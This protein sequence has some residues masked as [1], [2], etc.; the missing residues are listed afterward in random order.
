MRIDRRYLTE[1]GA[2]AEERLKLNKLGM[3]VAEDWWV[4]ANATRLI[5]GCRVA[6]KRVGRA[7][8]PNVDTLV[9]RYADPERGW[10][11]LDD[12]HRGLELRFD[13]C[14]HDIVARLGKPAI[15]AY[16]AWA[17]PLGEPIRRG[18]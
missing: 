15:K 18:L 8:D 6:E 1:I 14:R 11:R 13:R 12:L 9:A 10:W 4:I 7:S 16:W 3:E 2:W 5:N 17:Q